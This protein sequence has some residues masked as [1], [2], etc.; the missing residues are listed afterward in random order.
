MNEGTLRVL[1]C[2]LS[3]CLPVTWLA[4][5]D[6]ITWRRASPFGELARLIKASQLADLAGSLS[7]NSN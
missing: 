1:Y 3:A 7:C 6:V 4:R 5:F 2:A